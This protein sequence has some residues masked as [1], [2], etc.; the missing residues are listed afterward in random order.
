ME[1]PTKKRAKRGTKARGT[2]RTL[3]LSDKNWAVIDRLANELDAMPTTGRI[4]IGGRAPS[5]HTMIRMLGAG[6]L[7]LYRA[8][9]MQPRPDLLLWVIEHLRLLRPI[10]SDLRPLK[11]KIMDALRSGEIPE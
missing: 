3:W 1:E 2:Y 11:R 5:W 4:P 7:K 9:E 10:S 8:E 6:K